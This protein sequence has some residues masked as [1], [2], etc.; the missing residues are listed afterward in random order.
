MSEIGW[1]WAGLFLALWGLSACR[2]VSAQ[3]GPQIVV[4]ECASGS[5][6]W[7]EL[8]NRGAVAAE[9]AKDPASCWYVDDAEG[10]GSPKLL[11][12]TNLL[13]PTGSTTC[14]ALG[15]PATCGVIGPGE[16]V[17]IKFA[18]VN[19]T[20]AD[21]CRLLSAQKSGST[22]GPVLDRGAGGPTASASAGQ[23]F[24]RQPDG[25]GWATGAIACTQGA[26]NGGCTVGSA[27]DD[28]NACRNLSTRMR[29]RWFE[30]SEPPRRR[31]TPAL[32]G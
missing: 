9:L 3:T 31:A 24:G 18:F 23:C 13:H 10:G 6:G 27:C 30:F 4:N 22:C 19:A 20:S 15:R 28:G 17:W 11:G 14:S 8:L 21:A 7:I 32:V 2:G 12:D 5:S 16:H 25:A 29:Q 1:R 26:V